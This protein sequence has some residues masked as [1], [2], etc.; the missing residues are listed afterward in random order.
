MTS[1]H[2]RHIKPLILSALTGDLFAHPHI[3][4]LAGGQK[5]RRFRA[6]ALVHDPEVLILDEPTVGLDPAE[7]IAFRRHVVN[8][9]A[10]RVVVGCTQILDAVALAADTVRLVAASGGS[11]GGSLPELMAEAGQFRS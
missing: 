10:S 2:D 1:L 9:A 6:A 7:R 4:P 3:A 11:G 8:Q 5:S